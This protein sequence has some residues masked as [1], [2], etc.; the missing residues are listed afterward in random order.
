MSNAQKP[1]FPRTVFVHTNRSVWTIKYNIFRSAENEND[2]MIN[3]GWARCLRKLHKEKDGIRIATNRINHPNMQVF[4]RWK[5][6]LVPFDVDESNHNRNDVIL[7]YDYHV[8]NMCKKLVIPAQEEYKTCKEEMKPVGAHLPY[9][10]KRI[11]TGNHFQPL[12]YTYKWSKYHIVKKMVEFI[13]PLETDGRIWHDYIKEASEMRR[14][15]A[16]L[17]CF[18]YGSKRDRLLNTVNIPS[19]DVEYLTQPDANFDDEEFVNIAR[20]DPH[21]FSS[22]PDGLTTSYIFDMHKNT[23]PVH[24]ATGS[25]LLNHTTPPILISSKV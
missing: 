22:T 21:G 20:E 7:F 17:I 13:H 14:D 11:R 19:D 5:K 8:W 25:N 18:V 24:V 3:L 4:V 12:E 15:L 1:L 9:C 2:V 6:P 10:A 23:V 16:N